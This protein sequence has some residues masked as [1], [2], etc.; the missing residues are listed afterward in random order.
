MNRQDNA[1][2]NSI[3][4]YCREKK[5][6]LTSDC[7]GE[8]YYRCGECLDN[9]VSVSNNRSMFCNDDDED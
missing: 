5:K 7:S 9:P 6:H 8:I 4:Q 3:C 2:N 1:F